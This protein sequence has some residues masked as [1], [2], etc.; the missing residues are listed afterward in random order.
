MLTHA[1]LL[2][3]CIR[4]VESFDPLKTT[5][6]AHF[7]D[8][9]VV[10][11]KTPP[12]ETKFVQQVFYGCVRYQ[13]FLKVFVHSFLY[14]NP[15][16]AP[17]SDQTVYLIIAYLLFFRLEELGVDELRQ[18]IFAGLSTPP[19]LNALLQFCFSEENLNHWVKEEWCKIYDPTFVEEQIIKK[20]HS[21][22]PETQPL[23]NDIEF[24]ATGKLGEVVDSTMDTTG[25]RTKST[26][27]RPFNL[28]KPKP[29]LIP[30][31]VPIDRVIEAKPPPKTIYS[32]SLTEIEEEKK[33]RREAIKAKVATKYAAVPE[34]HLRTAERP[35]ADEY[36]KE[37]F[38]MEMD[39]QIM[40]DCT[41]QPA[42]AKE[43]VRAGLSEAEI[44]MNTAAILRED[45][46]VKDK[47]EKEYEVLKNYECEL[48]DASEFYRWQQEMREDDTIQEQ[49]RVAQR[50]VEMQMARTEAIASSEAQVRKNNAFAKESQA[51]MNEALENQAKAQKAEVGRK[52]ELVSIVT[53]ERVLARQAEQKLVRSKE[54][55]AEKV[56]QELKLDMERVKAEEEHEMERRKDLIRQIRAYERVASVAKQGAEFDPGEPPRHGFLDE[57]SL[58]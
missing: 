32:T 56:R 35:G 42:L 27:V 9:G 1:D 41:F 47:Q 33:K 20:L 57:M 45:K 28:T 16:V 7:T 50:K 40:N 22:R 8:A 15:A 5:V 4:I 53:K 24:T 18:F 26:V 21:F 46:L 6:D 30:Q 10:T 13:K 39:R 29:R 25:G 14:K 12:V 48:K 11:D 52:Q 3:M 23:L 49:L 38:R 55:V 37:Q 31:P 51:E 2:R 36:T 43:F 17:W 58:S 34:P 54:E 19:A 44:K